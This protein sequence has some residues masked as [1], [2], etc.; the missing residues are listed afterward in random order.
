[1]KKTVYLAIVLVALSAVSCLKEREL[2]P[3]GGRIV[4][5]AA[6]EYRNGTETRTIYSGDYTGTSTNYERIDWEDDDQITILYYH[7]TN[8]S[9]RSESAPYDI[10]DESQGV[11]DET[12][13]GTTYEDRKGTADIV[14]SGSNALEWA[15]ASI[16]KF[17]GLYP[18]V[19]SGR[20]LATATVSGNL[21]GRVSGLSIPNR[22]YV[23]YDANQGKYLPEN[24]DYAYMV[25]YKDMTSN[26]EQTVD[27]PFTPVVTAVEFRLHL[28]DAA[29]PSY[30]VKKVEFKSSTALAGSYSVDI[31][32]YDS[33]NGCVTWTAGNFTANSTD[34][35][36]VVEFHDASGN[37]ATP[38]LPNQSNS[39]T[40]LNFT[41]F[42]LPQTISDPELL[43]KY[44]DSNN[45]Q[46]QTIKKITLTGLQLDPGKKYLV[47]NTQAGYDTFGYELA[48]IQGETITGHDDASFTTINVSSL[49]RS[50]ANPNYT[51]NVNW[52]VQY[53]NTT[54]SDWYDVDDTTYPL[55]GY[56]VNGGYT[57]TEDHTHNTLDV[58]LKI[59]NGST[60]VVADSENITP[61]DAAT[62]LLKAR[63]PKG[64]SDNPYDLSTHDLNG[65]TIGQ[66][67]AN[68]YVVTAPG[69]Y[70]FPLIY[71]N[72]RV[73]GVDNSEAYHPTTDSS[74]DSGTTVGSDDDAQN[75]YLTDF[76]N[77]AG[78][79]IDSP[80]ILTDLGN[81]WGH[82]ATVGGITGETGPTVHRDTN[83]GMDAGNITNYSVVGSG[84]S[85][86]IK[87]QVSENNITP[88]N[89]RLL[90]KGSAVNTE[91]HG[92]DPADGSPILWSW[93]IW[94]TDKD[95]T[96]QNG[97]M[98][99]NLGWVD[100]DQVI[101]GSVSKY[102]DRALQ[103]KIVQLEGTTP[104]STT[105]TLTQN[106]DIAR[107]NY[108]SPTQGTS[109]LF[110]WGRKDP[111]SPTQSTVPLTVFSDDG[112]ST[113]YPTNYWYWR[114]IRFPEVMLASEKSRTW[115]DGKAIPLYES[116][117]TQVFDRNDYYIKSTSQK[118]GP[119]TDNQKNG[120]AAV[121]AFNSGVT[122]YH[123]RITDNYTLV[124]GTYGPFTASQKENITGILG[125]PTETR[126]KVDYSIYHAFFN[127]DIKTYGSGSTYYVTTAWS[128]MNGWWYIDEG[129]ILTSANVTMLKNLATAQVQNGAFHAVYASPYFASYN[130]GDSFETYCLQNVFYWTISSA[131]SI[132]INNRNTLVSNGFSSNA[133]TENWHYGSEWYLRANN[134]YPSGPYSESVRDDL[135]NTT[136]FSSSDFRVDP[137]YTTT[138]TLSYTSDSDRNAGSILYNLWSAYRYNENS[139]DA[140]SSGDKM[141][142][143]YDPCPPG[144][145]VPTRETYLGNNSLSNKSSSNLFSGGGEGTDY[146][147]TGAR[148]NTHAGVTGGSPDYV[149]ISN[150][151]S[152]GYYWTDHPCNMSYSSGDKTDITSYLYYQ[153]AYILKNT[154]SSSTTVEHISRATAAAV[155]PMVDPRAQSAAGITSQG[156]VQGNSIEAIT[157][158]NS[159][160]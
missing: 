90:L 79:V 48:T 36:V 101:T 27:L 108:V 11:D 69:W 145:T 82:T 125:N 34:S 131:T 66:T 26:A 60:R 42:V 115:M 120:L 29:R 10:V 3:A 47:Y 136:V 77:A 110:Q 104:L 109:S 45:P 138:T 74:W 24:M 132:T 119:F 53:Y 89:T 160:Y 148:L 100:K 127:S 86:Y 113:G 106:G 65:N 149:S 61:F 22:Q 14:A 6:T 80:Y 43:I 71:G 68:C 133:F 52:K 64:T 19:G 18:S 94:V 155:R 112:E 97:V 93:H 1:M 35:N 143:V 7:E 141:K 102:T 15:D 154:S 139:P 146:P 16:H 37:A 144:F 118:T 49:K 44:A 73:L 157:N 111:Y 58:S 95:L 158:G 62:E 151:S 20:T 128:E 31:T 32:G 126:K 23:K 140:P 28:P 2:H 33:T 107:V 12:A 17:F 105:F 88:G 147:Y 63:T 75:Y 78:D 67:A 46:N 103:L 96:P 81:L 9:G 85:A 70:K 51:E 134:G 40:Y 21:V 56:S 50:R 98:P 130:D 142:T 99:Y 54:Q 25:A 135:I 8:G 92:I 116:T 152:I 84:S 55:S 114:G 30:S 153:D 87:F 129:T 122:F 38:S 4:F 137:Q 150:A 124:A 159:L 13:G 76:Y 121:T 5:T 91:Y 123:D 83:H 117:Q 39:Q 41:L 59:A 57:L 156:N 72:A